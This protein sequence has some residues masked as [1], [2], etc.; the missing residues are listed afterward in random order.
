MGAA[1]TVVLIVV[2]LLVLVVALYAVST[3]A[4][5]VRMRD[6]AVEAGALADQRRSRLADL[7]AHVSSQQAS[8]VE[9]DPQTVK[10]LADAEHR[11]AGDVAFHAAAVRA[12][13]AKLHAVPASWV[14]AVSGLHPL[15][16]AAEN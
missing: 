2:V 9:P 5:L 7:A 12:Y 8:D 1:G 10:A 15:G 14:G 13:D 11:L 16:A 3:R 4:A 6:L